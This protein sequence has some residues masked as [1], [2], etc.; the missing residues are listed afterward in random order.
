[1]SDRLISDQD[2][3]IAH[4][5]YIEQELKKKKV[6]PYRPVITVYVRGLVNF[7]INLNS[8][9]LFLLSDIQLDNNQMW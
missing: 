7:Y 1:M 4:L 8:F 9:E 5:F 3:Y 6:A 2:A